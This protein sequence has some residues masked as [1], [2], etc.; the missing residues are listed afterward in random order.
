MGGG[1]A[2]YW[3]E[4]THDKYDCMDVYDQRMLRWLFENPRSHRQLAGLAKFMGVSYETTYN[5]LMHLAL[6]DVIKLN[7]PTKQT[8]FGVAGRVGY[9]E[10]PIVQLH[11]AVSGYIKIEVS[12]RL[13]E[14]LVGIFGQGVAV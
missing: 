9:L 4:L 6:A 13:W 14:Q 11:G 10:I 5:R 3:R 12:A 7:Y 8:R 1:D 2:A